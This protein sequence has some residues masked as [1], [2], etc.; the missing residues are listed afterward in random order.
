MLTEGRAET[1]RARLDEYETGKI[2][3]SRA[4][5]G[6]LGQFP[7]AS[8]GTARGI[9]VELRFCHFSGAVVDNFLAWRAVE[10]DADG[11]AENDAAIVVAAFPHMKHPA[12]IAETPAKGRGHLRQ[13]GT[14][15]RLNGFW[16]VENPR[17]FSFQDLDCRPRFFDPA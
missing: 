11:I 8:C 13:D 4:L 12:C 17:P 15:Q 1:L 3:V 9:F 5:G 10:M 6:H 2:I 7:G 16:V 14:G